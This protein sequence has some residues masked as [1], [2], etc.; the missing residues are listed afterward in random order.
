MKY[1]TKVEGF[2]DV[3][4]EKWD[5]LY[6]K[7]NWLVYN[8]NKI[9]RKGLFD[10]YDLTF[11]Y[12]NKPEGK[13]VLDL[14]CGTG[15]Y[16]IELAKKG[17]SS[18][19]VD[20]SKN[21][22]EIAQ[23]NAKIMEVED[24]CQFIHGNFLTHK[25]SVKFDFTIAL[26]FFDYIYN[27]EKFFKKIDNSTNNMFLASFPKK[28]PIWDIQRKIRYNIIGKCKVYNYS[29]PQLESLYKKTTF[30]S[31]RIINIGGGFFV[32]AQK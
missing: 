27:P 21:M 7:E 12:I 3:K 26:G 11:E 1:K 32:I 4:A 29:I 30:S 19:G 24:D 15:R 9:L 10:R 18:V 23:Q 13:T 14:G 6:S 25:F 5:A 8:L 31:F 17:A 28:R 20:I 2:F 16:A 22:I